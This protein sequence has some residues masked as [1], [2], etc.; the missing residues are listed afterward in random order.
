[1]APLLNRVR[2][3]SV[4]MFTVTFLFIFAEG[5]RPSDHGLQYQSSSP[6]TE[7]HSPPS[8][9][10]SFFGDSHSS[11]PPSQLLPKAT[12]TDGG[13]DDTWWRDGAANRR[14]HVMRH[15]FLAASIICGVSGVALL[16]VF[17][18]VYFFRYRNQNLSNLPC[19]DL[20]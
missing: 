20:K 10:M 19:N 6:P 8:K 5:L 12:D 9:M 4:F 1:M 3:A 2:S 11:P 7:S 13:D 17:T 16:V 18:L 14:E 15:V